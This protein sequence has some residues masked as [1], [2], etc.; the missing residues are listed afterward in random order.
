MSW[1]GHS[2]ISLPLR[3]YIGLVF[4]FACIHKI[5]DPAVFA[6]DVATYQ[7]MPLQLI[8]LMA[9][10]LPWLELFAGIMIIIGWR[11]RA[12]SL[13]IAGM[14]AV[15]L[16]AIII[17]LAR[18]LEMSCGCFASQSMEKDPI[19]YLT[20]LRDLGWTIIP[21][22]VLFFDKNPIGVD[23][24]VAYLIGRKAHA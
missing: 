6:V 9:V 4:V 18:G 21:L 22:Y 2:W 14:M 13:C 12:A 15:F 11:T 3:L 19:S 17:A 8:N 1:K 24:L 10:I 7:I 23:R 20:V 5:A 16:T